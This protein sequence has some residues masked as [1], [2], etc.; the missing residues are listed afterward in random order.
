M[1]DEESKFV[2]CVKGWLPEDNLT[3]VLYS[4]ITTE[5]KNEIH[6]SGIRPFFFNSLIPILGGSD[7]SIGLSYNDIRHTL[8]YKVI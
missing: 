3:E 7:N 2:T 1:I 4:N 8:R 6:K 5:I